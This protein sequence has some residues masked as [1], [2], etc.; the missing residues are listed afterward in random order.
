MWKRDPWS[1]CHAGKRL[2]RVRLL[3]IAMVSHPTYVAKNFKEGPMR[4]FVMNEDNWRA[5]YSLLRAIWPLIVLLR[6]GDTNGATMGYLYMMALKTKRLIDQAIASDTTDFMEEVGPEIKAAFEMYAQ[7]LMHKYAK[8]AFVLSPFFVD[9]ARIECLADPSLELA[10][11]EVARRVLSVSVDAGKLEASVTEVVEGIEDFHKKRGIYDR[12]IA[13][14]NNPK[15]KFSPHNWHF[16]YSKENKPLRTVAMVTLSKPI[17]AGAAER[18]W[19]NLKQVWDKHSGKMTSDKAE[20]RTRIYGMSHR[21]PLL[22]GKGGGEDNDV[23]FVWRKED[24]TFDGLGLDAWDYADASALH[25]NVTMA[26]R[27][28]YNY[29]EEGEPIKTSSRLAEATLIKKYKAIRFYD[30]EEGEK[31]EKGDGGARRGLVGL[32]R[33]DAKRERRD[34]P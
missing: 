33:Q 13:W 14:N 19:S 34:G 32:L 2:L 27:K 31:G 28:F 6:L 24:E 11:E 23:Q 26:R 7:H 20:K 9:E 4:S 15:A 5:I 29:I 3:L 16:N 17:G 22:T 30:A 12:P 18:D 1:E 10:L 8:A 21:D 25:A